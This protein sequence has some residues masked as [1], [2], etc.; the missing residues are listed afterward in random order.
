M[1][2][3]LLNIIGCLGTGMLMYSC[4]KP[5]A[6]MPNDKVEIADFYATYDG[7]G[8][9]RTFNSRISNDTVYVNVDYYYP[10][11]SDNEVDLTKMLLK[12]SI[13]VDSKISPALTGYTDL[14]SPVH[15]TVTA[16]D[17]SHKKYVIVAN[18]KGN[19]DVLSA[20]MT[21]EDFTGATQEVDAIIIGDKLNFS[22][23]PGTIVNNPR[24]TYQLNRHATA[25]INNGAAVNLNTPAPLVI[26]S[27]GNAKKNYT[28]QIVEA[29][30]LA[31]G[32]RPGSAKIMFA[33]KL[34]ADIGIS[35]DNLT[36]G[37]AAT[38]EYV[39]LNTRD[40]NSVVI[41][42]LTGAKV[43]E[44]NL[45]AIRGSVR[46]FYTTADDGGHILVNNLTPNDGAEFKIWKFSSI[47]S[48]P[49]LLISWNTGGSTYGRKISVSGDITKNA[50]ITA[51]LT[52]LAS[53]NTFA[54]WQIINGSLVSQ[55]P[56]IVAIN[57]YSWSWNNADVVYTNG[58]DLNS[59]YFAIGYSGTATNKLAKIN[60]LTHNV[61][62]SLNSL[63]AN[64]V[65]NAVDYIE[66]NN[67]KYAAYTHLNGFTWGSADQAFLI[68]TEVGMTGDPNTTAS[69]VWAAPKGAYGPAA[70][71]QAA[72]ANSTSDV[73][74]TTSE[75]GYFIYMYFM[76][77]NGYVVGVQFDCVDL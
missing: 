51:T 63:D 4:A 22:L 55:T 73:A 7:D 36:G 44:V 10:I 23:V 62:A 16:G 2:K 13:P 43:G 29:K 58:S 11:N 66:F 52:G 14:T 38:G 60:G 50:I 77:T 40:Q 5:D 47:T 48:S 9:T 31:K 70:A 28:M 8:R 65:C 18:K 46:N 59:D 74:L 68:D 6:V 21:Y 35:V 30:K 26:S 12:A 15:I 27:V 57:N 17:G 49:E 61:A 64:F 42:A 1:N 33:K 19:T 53:Q 45:G 71:Q 75:N 41:N 67:S 24:V 69:L 56:T 37:I 20:K 32:I 25:S 76:F 72:N 3:F 54:R 34:K 39:V